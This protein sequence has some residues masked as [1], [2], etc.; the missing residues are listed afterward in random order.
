MLDNFE[1]LLLPA[2][3]GDVSGMLRVEAQFAGEIKV[4]LMV[5]RRR[6]GGFRLFM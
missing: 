6:A 4:S 1:Y 2:L 5:A 3:G